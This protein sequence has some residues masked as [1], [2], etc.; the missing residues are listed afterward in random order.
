MFRISGSI[1]SFL[2]SFP[3]NNLTSINFIIL[4]KTTISTLTVITTT[5]SSASAG[6]YYVIGTVGGII[7]FIVIAVVLV[8]TGCIMIKRQ[9]KSQNSC[10]FLI[11]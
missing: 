11:L 5:S 10:N 6:I 3:I 4:I 2:S 8:L 9:N 1:Y 7:V